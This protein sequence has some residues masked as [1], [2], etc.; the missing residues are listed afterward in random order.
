MI[1]LKKEFGF[2]PQQLQIKA[3]PVTVSPL[4]DLERTASDV[5]ASDGVEDNWFYAPPQQV[6]DLMSGKVAGKRVSGLLKIGTGWRMISLKKSSSSR[7][8]LS[9]NVRSS[10]RLGFHQ[11]SMRSATDELT[12]ASPY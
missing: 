8:L 3:G 1:C 2:Y 12:I 7:I 11:N 4:P 10:G 6:R 5:L 9:H